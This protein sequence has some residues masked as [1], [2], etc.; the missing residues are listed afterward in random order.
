MRISDVYTKPVTA[1]EGPRRR[2]GAAAAQG[3]SPA[4]GP[5]D[6]VAFSGQSFEVQRA[7]ALALQA[8]DIREDVVGVIVD[9]LRQGLYRITGAEV[10]PRLV[11]EHLELR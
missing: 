3:P 7:R 4:A 1:V 10:L 11:R 9:Q 2:E 6:Q 5:A 8:P